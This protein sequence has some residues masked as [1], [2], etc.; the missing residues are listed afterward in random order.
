MTQTPAFFFD[1]LENLA[2]GRCPACELA[3]QKPLHYID[4]A[5]YGLATDPH[6]QNLFAE[7]GG[8]CRRHAEMLL[9]IPWGSALGVAILYNR[10]IEDGAEELKAAGGDRSGRKKHGGL[11]LN[12]F[13]QKGRKQSLS[14]E[15]NP[16][17]L[18]CKVE[19][20]TEQGVLRTLV[21]TLREGDGRMLEAVEGSEGFCLYHL[22]LAFGLAAGEKVEGILRR[23]GLRRAERLLAELKEFIRKSDYRFTKEQMGAEGDSWMRAV[24]WV[25]GVSLE[26]EDRAFSPG[27]L[28]RRMRGE[29]TPG[30]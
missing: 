7:T 10:L 12:I 2:Q 15:D 18:A 19:H 3:R 22:D 29:S 13:S 17:C 4:H 21:E 23:H 30:E 27:E 24:A 5:L 25:T 1:I 11:S 16:E 28:K 9:K 14:R 8:Y 6:A 20:E 26:K